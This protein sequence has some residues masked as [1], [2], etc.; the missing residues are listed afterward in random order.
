M[1]NLNKQSSAGFTLIEVMIIVV[2]VGILAAIAWPS[3]QNFLRQ[4]RLERARADLLT[5]AQMMNVSIAN[6]TPLHR[7]PALKCRA[8]WLRPL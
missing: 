1:N 3:Y 8:M 5:N 4:T 2:I 7:L 6:A